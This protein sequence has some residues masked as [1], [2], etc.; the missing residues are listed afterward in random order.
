MNAVSPDGGHNTV[1]FLFIIVFEVQCDRVVQSDLILLRGII[2]DTCKT[3]YP[4]QIIDAS[5]VFTVGLFRR[6]VLKI[7]R[8]IA[9][10][11]SFR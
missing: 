7:F 1:G 5:V 8:A 2:D 6:I 4:L 3:E 10:S 9:R 11:T